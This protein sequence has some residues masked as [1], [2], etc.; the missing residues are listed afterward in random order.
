M[1]KHRTVKRK[2]APAVGTR[3]VRAAALGLTVVG[4]GLLA[5][6]LWSAADKAQAAT[7]APGKG[8]VFSNYI[9]DLPV[10]P[11][12]AED[13]QGYAFDLYQGG[14]LAEARLGGQA[15]AAVVRGFYAATLTQLGWRASETEPYVYRRGRERL[16]FLVEPRRARK[17]ARPVRGLEAV[18][19][20]TPDAGGPSP[21]EMR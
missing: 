21:V 12:L 17:G 6:A 11:G 14:R 16:I 2:S 5:A 8:T 13:D 20:I 19:V 18:F 10:M 7:T 3:T 1:K 4:V 9:D 15:E